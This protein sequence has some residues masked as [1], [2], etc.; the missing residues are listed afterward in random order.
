[1][2]QHDLRLFAVQAQNAAPSDQPFVL[3]RIKRNVIKTKT[4]KI[5]THFISTT[6]YTYAKYGTFVKSKYK[7][8]CF[9]AEF[10]VKHQTGS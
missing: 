7:W 4:I 3:R 1:M 5:L 2:T 8:F 9:G 10:K 6:N